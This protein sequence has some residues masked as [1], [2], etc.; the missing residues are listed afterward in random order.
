MLIRFAAFCLTSVLMVGS[1]AAQDNSPPARI[2]NV[3]NGTAHEPN[4]GAVRADESAAGVAPS[5]SA[6]RAD[7]K[8]VQQLD[9][10]VQSNGAQSLAPAKSLACTT[11]PA[12]CQR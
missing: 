12:S 9:H 3:Y 11:V 6:A 5:P 4:A 2:G 7:N 1:A 10:Q 8:A